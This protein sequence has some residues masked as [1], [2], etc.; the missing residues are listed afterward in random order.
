MI[1]AAFLKWPGAMLSRFGRAFFSMYCSVT[2]KMVLL[3]FRATSSPL[4]P[5]TTIGDSFSHNAI[6]LEHTRF[7]EA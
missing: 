2:G 1:S 4:R 5:L 7:S 3:I 6:Y